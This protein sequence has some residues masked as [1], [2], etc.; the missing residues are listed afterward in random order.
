MTILLLLGG[1]FHTSIRYIEQHLPLYLA[2]YSRVICFEYPQFV[3][4]PKLITGSLTLLERI[5]ANLIV[6]HSIGFIP[7]GRTIPLFNRINHSLNTLILKFLVGKS[8][9]AIISFTPEL[10]LVA[11]LISSNKII[12]H[13]L[14]EYA[15]LPWW[16]SIK[17][18]RA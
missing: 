10:A 1:N 14:D 2:R 5:N 11:P 4:F 6:L 16:G 7:R 13:V 18:R 17:L 3:K 8:F 12:Y 15:S 9:D